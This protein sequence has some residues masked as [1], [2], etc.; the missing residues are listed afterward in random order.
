MICRR[1]AL[2]VLVLVAMA[3]SG[4][5]VTAQPPGGAGSKGGQT[6]PAFEVPEITYLVTAEEYEAFQ[7][8]VERSQ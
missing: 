1:S 8:R 3:W 7:Q 4:P 2:L 6:G 5:P